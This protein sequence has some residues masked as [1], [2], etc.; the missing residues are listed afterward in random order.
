MTGRVLRRTYSAA[1]TTFQL[2]GGEATAT[3]PKPRRQEPRARTVPPRPVRTFGNRTECYENA[4]EVLRSL[5]NP[6]RDLMHQARLGRAVEAAAVLPVVNEIAASMET[7]PTALIT[8][9]RIKARD[10][11][12]YIHAIAVCALMINLGR[13]LDLD[14][15]SLRDLGVAG[16]L[17]DIGETLLPAGLLE[18]EARFG[19]KEFALV[20]AHPQH[21]HDQ[22]MQVRGLP[23]VALDVCLH[24]HE[25][26]DGA[27]YP[28]GK[29][30]MQ[31]SLEAKMASICDVYDAITSDRP[32][33]DTWMPPAGLSEMFRSKGQFDASLLS[34]FIR[35]VGIFPTGSLVR[36][37]SDH[38]ALVVE[39]SGPEL[40]RPVVRIFYSILD[41]A[42]VPTREIDLSRDASDAIADRE[43]PRAWGFLD[44][45]HQWPQLLRAP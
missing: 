37:E 34:H 7:H 13:Q 12:A 5:K 4:S 20:R 45:N 15:G 27:G 2:G 39:Q 10:E 32:Y 9:A 35:G 29:G 16:L 33:D 8:L 3:A 18:R 44:W 28:S 36:L 17:H 40:T 30:E 42:R 43:E 14:Q 31:L 1:S 6:V 38:L 22:L 21:G 11:R 24:H 23:A 26:V 25:R 41:R 19:D